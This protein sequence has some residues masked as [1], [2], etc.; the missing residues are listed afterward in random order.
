MGS[1]EPQHPVETARHLADREY[2][3]VYS[4][5]NYFILSESI[6][7]TAFLLAFN[8]SFT[9]GHLIYIS[10]ALVG[11]AVSSWWIAIG[12]RNRRSLDAARRM[13]KEQEQKLPEVDM[14]VYLKFREKR[15]KGGV[16][17][18]RIL[19]IYIPFGFGFIWLWMLILSLNR[20]AEFPIIFRFK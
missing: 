9:L 7:L 8:M 18:D 3:Y 4:R 12:F 13:V 14:R 5:S 6:L 19:L 2:D 11:L 17:I 16:S 10:I 20:V 1:Q 15:K